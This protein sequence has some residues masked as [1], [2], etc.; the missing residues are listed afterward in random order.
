MKALTAMQAAS[1][2][3]RQSEPHLGGVAAHLYAEF[4]GHA[5]DAG[6]LR[7]AVEALYQVHPMLRLR[8]NADGQQHTDGPLPATLL[9]VDDLRAATP[10][11]CEA[12]LAERRL[13]GNTRLPDLTAGEACEIGL[14]QLS[15]DRSRLHVGLDMIAGDAE[16]FRLLVEDLA[17]F[18]H[19][20]RL[21]IAAT[22]NRFFHWLEQHQQATNLQ[23]RDRD[24]DWWRARL[25]SIPPAPPVPIQDARC[26]IDRLAVRLDA[27]QKQALTALARQQH[28]TLSALFL[29]LFAATLA[30]GWA[31]PRFRLNVPLF[32][33]DDYGSK[34][35][36]IIG[37]FT[38]LLIFN[39]EPD[40]AASVVQYGQQVMAQLGELISHAAWPG[41]N[42]MRDLSRHHGSLQFSPVVFTAGF[43]IDGDELWSE[44]V[45]RTFGSMNWVI[46]QGPQVALDAQVAACD[47]GIL[48]NWDLRRDAFP[49]GSIDGLFDR[50]HQLLSQLAADPERA[51]QPLAAL[52]PGLGDDRAAD[53]N[54]A[55]AAGRAA[56]SSASHAGGNAA[57][58]SDGHPGGNGAHGSAGGAASS[59]NTAG[60]AQ[61][62]AARAM[63]TPSGVSG[64][65]AAADGSTPLTPLQQAYLMGRSELWSLG[66]VA[67]HEFREYRGHADPAALRA[68]LEQL[69]AHYA[70]LRTCIDSDRLTQRVL[71]AAEARLEV[72]D[73]RHL[74][75]A[76]ALAQVDTLREQHSH[77]RH[78]PAQPP[79]G[80]VLVQLADGP[81]DTVIFTSFDALILDGEGISAIITRLFDDAP[82]AAAAT[83]ATVAAPPVDAAKRLADQHYWQQKLQDVSSPS[84]L[85][86]S[87]P[88]ESIR[89]SRYRRQT[90]TVSREQLKALSKVGSAQKLFR[91]TTLS[92]II[93]DTLALWTP[94]GEICV[95]VPVAFPAAGGNLT[96]A[97]TFIVA[98]WRRDA[99]A[100]LLA[101]AA[102]FQ[103]DLLTS[104]DHLAFSGV[105]L[106][107]LLLN[108]ESSAPGLPVILTNCLSWTNLPADAPVRFHDGLTQTP[109][110]AMDIRLNLD[111]HK[112]LLLNIDYAEQA[113]DDAMITALLAAIGER[114]QRLCSG[115]PADRAAEFLPCDHYRHNGDEQQVAAYPFLAVLA[116]NLFGGQLNNTALICGERRY[117]YLQLGEAVHTAIS[118]L[119]Q[120]DVQP[121]EVIALHLPRGPEM[122]I[123]QLACALL[124][125]VWLPIDIN[126]PPERRHYLLEN[127][128]PRWVVSQDISGLANGITPQQLLTP[129]AEHG[130]CPGAAELIA[131]SRSSEPAYFLYTSGTTGRPKCVVLNNRATANVL[132]HT[133]QRWQ[134]TAEDVLISVTPPHHDMSLFDLFGALCSGAT[135]V[136]P[137]A[138]QEKD[139]IAWNR[140][141]EQHR[142]SLWCSV[143]AILEMLLAC[144]AEGGLKSLRLIAQ[145]GDYIKPATVATLRTLPGQPRLFSLGGPTET[146]IWSIW[147][148]IEAGDTG[149]VPYGQPLPGVQYWICNEQGE[150]CPPGVTGR[151]HT[152]G[153]GL[154]LGYLEAG[155]LM[156]HDF[157]EVTTPQGESVRAFKTG[158]EGYYRTDGTIM[159]ASRINGYVKIRGIRVSLPEVEEALKQHPA[160]R[161]LVV[162]DFMAEA[163]SE[164]SLGLMY[165]TRDDRPLT[166]SALREFAARFLPASHIPTRLIHATALPLSSNGKTDRHQ[167]R[168]QCITAA[169]A[170][171]GE[172]PLQKV[173]SICQQ[174]AGGSAAWDENSVFIS[175]GMKL[176]QMQAIAADINQA[177]G[178]QLATLALIKCRTPKEVVALVTE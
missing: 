170:A 38:N 151:I 94:D 70:A 72:V 109:Q 161:D 156:Q 137:A 5:L 37:D 85:P 41:V 139:A 112:N 119:Q 47:G 168:Q 138:D 22:E 7:Q 26:H 178:R 52:L 12:F 89:R 100:P 44:Q 29:A 173:L 53:A 46:S 114:V 63:A 67:M 105:D 34:N 87:A 77:N 64:R 121:G 102:A 93:L 92:A 49:A 132:A 32:H 8:I 169:P 4:D 66:G 80:I 113:L 82:L 88:L 134:V 24:R 91:N 36:D 74:E 162:V 96:N 153:A 27:Q 123:S 33:R 55:A 71:P 81:F 118:Q 15:D 177:F 25:P 115:Q 59:G 125:A 6:R 11:E 10:T 18:Y 120:R 62:G 144:K 75:R 155:Q 127:S 51:T 16:S 166:Q 103:Q 39:A 20:P 160:I 50:Y 58:G 97:S 28:L 142:V 90:L 159:F 17:R 48:I 54:G 40:P 175:M 21:A 104:L 176:P 107:R 35:D 145:G 165:L 43:G 147:H 116:G 154:A 111:Q 140:L 23:Q 86:W 98:P 108:K 83:P 149:Q 126:S 141:V 129:V 148:E 2:V 9:R 143:P 19:H 45:Q 174:H 152:A 157:V 172:T 128:Q 13:H 95:G 65:P 78:D 3:G 131:R 31:L 164:A 171:T 117:S 167:I 99:A 122:I 146:T 150:H 76:A 68:R 106:S 136:L 158:D 79:Y 57:Q 14:T 56:L 163:R 60:L 101:Q 84:R 124:G 133:I 130:H 110:V 61:P 30:E 42:V 73:L 69:V 1:W 135:L